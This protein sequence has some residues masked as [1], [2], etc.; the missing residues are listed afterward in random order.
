M[1]QSCELNDDVGFRIDTPGVIDRVSSLFHG[2][3]VLIQGFNTFLPAGFRIDCVSTENGELITVTTPSGIRRQTVSDPMSIVE[4]GTDN[5]MTERAYP[6]RRAAL[7]EG[8]SRDQLSDALNI[9]QKVRYRYHENE[10][11]K[12]D[13]FLQILNPKSGEVTEVS[14]SW[15]L[16]FVRSVYELVLYRRMYYWRFLRCSRM[17]RRL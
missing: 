16:E 3:P 6:S 10:P 11:E 7:A 15:P 2:H 1:G 13:K 5:E 17:T 9:V 12:Y 14:S 8:A 4:P